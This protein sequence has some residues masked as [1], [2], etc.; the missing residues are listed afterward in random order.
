MG[1]GGQPPRAG[2]PPQPAAPT[3]LVL[4]MANVMG[5]RPDGW[6]RDR[7]GAA[8]R[9]LADV[10]PLVGRTVPGPSGDRVA[11]TRVVAVLEGPAR[12]ACPPPGSVGLDVV[13]AER[14]GDAAVAAVAAELVFGQQPAPAVLVV[15]AD[16]G[17]RRRLPARAVVTGPGWL[18]R[19]LASRPKAQ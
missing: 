14:D 9:W 19:T 17:L 8:T 11:I 12:S 15:T 2:Q 4:D 1:Q 13:A 3:V 7:A 5:S 18:T 10:A 6:W 16:R